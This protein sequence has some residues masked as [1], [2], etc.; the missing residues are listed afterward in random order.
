MK[1]A[2]RAIIIVILILAAATAVYAI[3]VDLYVRNAYEDRIL[4]IEDAAKLEDIDAVVVLGCQVKADGTPSSMLSDR[5]AT[6][7]DV[8]N[9]GVAPVLFMSGDNEKPEY[10]ETGKMYLLAV[11]RG[12]PGSVIEIDPYGLSTY[13]SMWRLKNVYGC[14]RILVVTQEY[15]L[16]RAIYDAEKMGMEAWGVSASVRTYAG[17]TFRDIREILARNKDFL[18]TWFMPDPKYATQ[19]IITINDI[20]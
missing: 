13:D 4:P 19:K 3:S 7:V 10:N 5:V 8:Y 1:K 12:V 2:I 14:K 6:G 11:E 20:P 18:F 9:T 15:H 17:Q 16:R